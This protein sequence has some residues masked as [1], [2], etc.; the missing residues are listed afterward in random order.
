MHRTLPEPPSYL[1][2]GI[3]SAQLRGRRRG[4]LRRFPQPEPPM[5]SPDLAAGLNPCPHRSW[6]WRQHPRATH[7]P[8]GNKANE[9]LPETR[10]W[11]PREGRGLPTAG[12]H[13]GAG[14]MQCCEHPP[15]VKIKTHR[16]QEAAKPPAGQ[17]EGASRERGALPKPPPERLLCLGTAA[18]LP[19]ARPF[20]H[21]PRHFFQLHFFHI[22]PQISLS[23]PPAPPASAAICLIS[24]P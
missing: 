18:A 6:P 11:V 22:S 13:Y 17:R 4:R 20:P 16:T 2:S 23:P 21:T 9:G 5:H 12:R 7:H 24:L 8:D 15:P 19:A 14:A 10:L 1:G 3:T